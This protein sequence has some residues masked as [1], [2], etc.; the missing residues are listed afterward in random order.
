MAE[1]SNEVL[2]KNF[3]YLLIKLSSKLSEEEGERIAFAELGFPVG[4]REKRNFQLH[5]CAN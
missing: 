2:P 4:E 3:R 1:T 5:V